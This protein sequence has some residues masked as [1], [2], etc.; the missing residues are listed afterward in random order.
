MAHLLPNVKQKFFDSNGV[1]LAGGKLYSYQAGTTTPL[2]TYTDQGAG[3]PNANPTI[4]DANG[5]AS[6]WISSAAYKFVLK[7]SDDNTLWTVDNVS[8]VSTGALSLAMLAD[9]ILTADSAGRLKMA[10]GYV[11]TDKL[12]DNALAAT[13]AG[14]GKLQDGFFS[15]DSTGRAKFA[16]SF[17][18]AAKI[19]ADAVTT[20]KILAGNVTFA[21]LDTDFIASATSATPALSD[22]MLIGDA[23]DSNLVKRA[24]LAQV[25]SMFSIGTKRTMQYLKNAGAATITN[26]G[27][28]SA[29]TT[30]GTLSSQ[31]TVTGAWLRHTTAASAGSAGGFVSSSY[32]IVRPGW[33]PEMTAY[34]QWGDGFN[35]GD[36]QIW[37]GFMS[38]SVDTSINGRDQE[39]STAPAI[40]MAGFYYGT[41][42]TVSDYKG[43]WVPYTSNGAAGV[44]NSTRTGA[45]GSTAEKLKIVFSSSTEVLFYINEVLVATHTATLPAENQA[46]GFGIRITAG[47]AAAVYLEWSRVEIRHV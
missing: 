36:G 5:E 38:A 9:G 32:G 18:N 37:V 2:A 6:I 1:A 40:A 35:A 7:D 19:E 16:D 28:A 33:L 29:P 11:N 23:S 41:A 30:A 3:T 13:A 45:L 27:F 24:T 42:T 12:A 10:D 21:K 17:I 26:S 34:V 20:D 14:R 8:H 46:L 39:S 31:D 47:D 4:L 43:Q 25:G 22:S 44:N 15:A